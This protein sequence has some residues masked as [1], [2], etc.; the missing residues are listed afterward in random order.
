MKTVAWRDDASLH[1]EEAEIE[2][3]SK[4]KETTAAEDKSITI[5]NLPIGSFRSQVYFPSTQSQSQNV[6]KE[7]NNHQPLTPCEQEDTI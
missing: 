2:D 6:S 5:D 3:A 4:M 1:L 7:N